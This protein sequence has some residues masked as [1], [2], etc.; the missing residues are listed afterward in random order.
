MESNFLR[1][2]KSS[3]CQNS[4][5]HNVNTKTILQDSTYN[6]AMKILNISDTAT[7]TQEGC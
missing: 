3:R 6:R 4:K 1:S 7:Y 2:S 5:I